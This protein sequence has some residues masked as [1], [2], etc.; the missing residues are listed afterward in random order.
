MKRNRQVPT[1]G[2][3]ELI[4]EAVHLMRGAPAGTLASYYL[5]A[6]PF[7]L[8]LLYFWADMSRS[9]FAYQHL[10]GSALGLSL[11]FVWMKVWQA[12]FSRRLRSSLA[13][14]AASPRFRQLC[15]MAVSQAVWQ[16]SGLFLLPLAL[17]PLILPFPWVFAFYQNLTAVA[18][19]DPSGHAPAFKKA[20]RLATLWPGQNRVLLLVLGA[21]GLCVFLNCAMMCFLLPFAAKNLLGVDSVFTRSGMA[22]LNTTFFAAMFGV[23]YLCVDPLVKA[24]YTLRCFYGESVRSGADLQAELRQLA[25]PV[26]QVAVCILALLPM[27]GV[28][29]GAMFLTAEQPPRA[30]KQFAPP[31][32]TPPTPTG[33]SATSVSPPEL[34]RSI[35]E[36]SQQPKYTWRAPREKII[37]PDNGEEGV[38]RRFLRRVGNLVKDWLKTLGNWL[39]NLLR[40]LFW[41]QKPFKFES[42]GYGWM[43]LLQLLMYALIAG[44]VL[45]LGFLLYRL[46]R[47]KHQP[48]GSVIASLPLQPAPDLQ[49]ENV[50]A[51]Q[52]PEDGWT[53]L[54]RELLA[55]GEL[56]LAARAFYL[57]SLAHLAQRNLISLAKF[58][59]NRDYERELLRRAHSFPDLLSVFSEN[60]SVFERIWYGL[61]E[62]NH[63]L[64]TRFAANVERIKAG[65]TI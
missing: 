35:Q 62:I 18:D 39:D 23:A 30:S 44:V 10:A 2:A 37:E 22:M 5:G 56:R 7:V 38:F 3:L 33:A 21:F 65:G 42:S 6:L 20:M 17:L 50:A 52:M 16:S 31:A 45:G 47:D 15:R 11:L 57:A 26:G 48:K 54:A 53:K 49:D 24:A 27:S 14:D 12:Q 36:V 8:A 40:K 13:G 43:V 46:W 4:E 59:S 25:L 64:V 1:K 34:D 9:P 61:H 32:A 51:D 55:R 41:R 19:S 63:E 28:G 60:V 29:G 58:K